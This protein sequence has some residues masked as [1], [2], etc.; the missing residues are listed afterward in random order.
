MKNE[1]ERPLLKLIKWL[2]RG[3]LSR[4]LYEMVSN[5]ITSQAIYLRI[6]LTVFFDIQKKV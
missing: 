1:V 3:H 5:E 6:V 4:F 2:I